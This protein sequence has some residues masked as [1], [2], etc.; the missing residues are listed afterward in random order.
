M[1]R[2]KGS[3]LGGVSHEA[4]MVLVSERA[5]SIKFRF[6]EGHTRQLI[7]GTVI[8]SELLSRGSD[9]ALCADVRTAEIARRCLF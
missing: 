7:A 8:W 2:K 9:P 5:H 3:L 6:S 1:R 4:G